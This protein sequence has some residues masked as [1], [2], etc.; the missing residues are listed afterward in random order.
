MFT[1]AACGGGAGSRSV[2]VVDDWGGAEL[3]TVCVT[4]QE[5]YGVSGGITPVQE[6]LRGLFA[7]E[8]IVDSGCDATI[9]VTTTGRAR[10][11]TYDLGDP[12]TGAPTSRLFTGADVAGTLTL[13]APDRPTLTAEIAGSRFPPASWN[14][15]MGRPSSAASAPFWTAAR[16]EVCLVL[17]GW[18]RTSE[19]AAV[20]VIV[21]GLLIDEDTVAQ[22]RADGVIPEDAPGPFP[23][24]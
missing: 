20:R 3:T 5:D 2:L 24:W 14:T 7:A 8:T 6:G 13:T 15:M 10:S 4:G 21:P 1:V 18:F 22:L 16:P 12:V 19:V 11:A 23:C 17:W 9:A